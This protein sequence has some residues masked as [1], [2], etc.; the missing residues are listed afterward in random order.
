MTKGLH[1]PAQLPMRMR[2][3]KQAELWLQIHPIPTRS[4]LTDALRATLLPTARE[5]VKLMDHLLRMGG[6][7]LVLLDKSPHLMAR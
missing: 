5:Q 6:A 1:D 2:S 3:N 7:S 4:P